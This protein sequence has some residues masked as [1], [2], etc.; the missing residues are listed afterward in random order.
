MSLTGKIFLMAWSCIVT[1]CASYLWWSYAALGHKSVAWC[2]RSLQ[3]RGGW[4]GRGSVS[5]CPTQCGTTGGG[6]GTARFRSPTNANA[7]KEYDFDSQEWW[8]RDGWRRKGYRKKKTTAWDTVNVRKLKGQ[9]CET[10]FGGMNWQHAKAD[11]RGSGDDWYFLNTVGV[12]VQ[13]LCYIRTQNSDIT[14]S[15][16]GY[17]QLH[18]PKMSRE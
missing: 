17:K 4:G 3:T 18:H 16:P 7:G 12:Q 1:S 14:T 5:T 15:F 6:R 2:P 13:G 9:L 10:S 8:G 11:I